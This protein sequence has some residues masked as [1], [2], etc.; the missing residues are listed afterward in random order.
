MI[1]MFEE[2]LIKALGKSEATCNQ[3]KNEI[4][5]VYAL[6]NANEITDITNVE[7]ISE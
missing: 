5:T 6:I 1:N 4:K 3:I 7:N 2:Y